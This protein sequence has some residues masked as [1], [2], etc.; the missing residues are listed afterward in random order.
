MTQNF[1]NWTIEDH[2]EKNRRKRKVATGLSM[3]IPHCT[4]TSE[5]WTPGISAR[6]VKKRSNM[7]SAFISLIMNKTG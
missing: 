4:P 5:E 1:A 7:K 6:S 2:L 3:K